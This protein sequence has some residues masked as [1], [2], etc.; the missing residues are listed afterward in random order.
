[1]K[2]SDIRRRAG[3]NAKRILTSFQDDELFCRESLTVQDKQGRL[4]PFIWGPAQRR[5]FEA[6]DRQRLKGLPVRIIYLK[7]RQ[8]WVSTAVAGKFWKEIAFNDGQRAQVYAHDDDS[9]QKIFEY[10]K[11]FNDHYAP[12]GGVLALPE[13]K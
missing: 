9:A 12:F 3:E 11:R 7:G 4:V 8:V 10:Y 6:I 2:E 13:V 1:M 5:L